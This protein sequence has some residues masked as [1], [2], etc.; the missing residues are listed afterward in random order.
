MLLWTIKARLYPGVC[1]KLHCQSH[2]IVPHNC[3]IAT[4]CSI[5]TNTLGQALILAFTWLQKSRRV[6]RPDVVWYDR[7]PV[8]YSGLTNIKI[9]FFTGST[10]ACKSWI[11]CDT[12]VK[13][14]KKP[15]WCSEHLER[16]GDGT[17]W[18]TTEV[19]HDVQKWC[20]ISMPRGTF[21]LAAI[22]M[23]QRR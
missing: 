13:K 16:W 10:S 20:H 12:L 9:I 14:K 17:L 19:L 7:I 1:W 21:I 8:C 11:P 5:N 6:L 3:L 23:K 18:R 15:Y 4:D 2:C 22:S